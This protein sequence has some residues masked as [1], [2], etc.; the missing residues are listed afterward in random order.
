VGTAAAPLSI[1]DGGSVGGE[2]ERAWEGERPG[3]GRAVQ[4]RWTA[5]GR[6]RS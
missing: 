1:E 2:G 5:G 4:G 6:R 3:V